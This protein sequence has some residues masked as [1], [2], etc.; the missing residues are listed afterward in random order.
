MTHTMLDAELVERAA[1]TGADQPQRAHAGP[2]LV[3]G[4]D[5]DHARGAL[6]LAELLARR[7]R[8]NAHVLGVVRP[9]SFPVSVLAGADSEALEETH[10]R[11]HAERM[12]ARLHQA[13]GLAAFFTVEAVTGDAAPAL[14]RAARER[15][16][17]IIMVGV[18][19]QNAPNRAATEDAALQVARAADVPVLAVPAGHALLPKH[20]LVAMD[21]SS[22]SRRAAQAAIPLLAQGATLTL[23]YVEP[24]VDFTAL[25]E[26]GWAE[27]HQRGVSQL[28]EQLAA[29]LSIPGDVAVETLFLR[30][31]AAVALLDHARHG[32]FDLVAT[33]TQ[34]RTALDRHLTASVSTALLRGAEC[35]VLIAPPPEAAS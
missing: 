2:L 6:L 22:A 35:A 15:G 33:G 12:R 27:I 20:A 29:S 18:E 26:E 25:G 31:D 21:F 14:A 1:E 34:G 3:A 17:E 28:F 30:G 8:V 19:E 4:K 7:D 10:R 24:E 32:D 9:L 5:A 11:L 13:T 16:S 23:A